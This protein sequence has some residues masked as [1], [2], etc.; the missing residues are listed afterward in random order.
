M[1]ENSPEMS[2]AISPPDAQQAPQSSSPAGLELALNSGFPAIESVLGMDSGIVSDSPFAVKWPATL[3]SPAL[4]SAGS[5][6][7]FI[8]TDTTTQGNWKGTYG[9]EGYQIVGDSVSYPSYAQVTAGM[10]TFTWEASSSSVRALQKAS[11]ST[12]RIASCWY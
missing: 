9:A 7:H 2:P 8:K 3:L 6:A 11:S 10:S 4:Q 1:A 5:S 12:E